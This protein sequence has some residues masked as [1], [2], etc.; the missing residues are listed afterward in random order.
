MGVRTEAMLLRVT[1]GQED[2]WSD[3]PLYEA[4]VRKALEHGM[5]GATAMPCPS[6]FGRSRYV[7]SELNV[8]AGAKV[9]MVVEIVDSEE[10]ID[11]FL[12]VIDRMV[13]SGLVTIEKVRAVH[14][15]RGT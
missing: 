14:Y 5:A 15:G 8:D 2:R 6:G 12:P 13:E 1:V 7:R 9:P 4:I 11:R 10:Q 3:R